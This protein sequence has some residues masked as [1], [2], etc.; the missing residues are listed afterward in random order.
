[1]RTDGGMTTFYMQL[2][3]PEAVALFF[4]VDGAINDSV[5]DDQEEQES[6]ARLVRLRDA[7]YRYIASPPWD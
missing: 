5:V 2:N 3:G 4:L 6:A 1:M 7:L